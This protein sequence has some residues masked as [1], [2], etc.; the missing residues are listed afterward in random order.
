M[1]VE[2][3]ENECGQ[4]IGRHHRAQPD[5]QKAEGVE[6]MSNPPVKSA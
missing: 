5:K 4:G 6:G 1:E 2:G 3:K